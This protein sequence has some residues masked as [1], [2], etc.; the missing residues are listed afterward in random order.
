M[1]TK[2]QKHIMDL[3]WTTNFGLNF[4]EEGNSKANYRLGSNFVKKWGCNSWEFKWYGSWNL[5]HNATKIK[6]KSRVLPNFWV[7]SYCCTKLVWL[8]STHRWQMPHS[9]K[10]KL[11]KVHH[12]RPIFTI[13]TAKRN[14]SWKLKLTN[15]DVQASKSWTL[16]LDVHDQLWSMR[17][18]N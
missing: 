6:I 7:H 17:A 8:H 15:L 16:M 12:Y 13:I 5:K 2:F 10:L 14:L 18:I 3:V 1:D 4:V 11:L 9:H